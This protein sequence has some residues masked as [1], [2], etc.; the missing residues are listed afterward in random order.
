MSSHSNPLIAEL[1]QEILFA[2]PRVYQLADPTPLEKLETPYPFELYLKREDRSPIRAYK[3]RGAYNRMAQLSESELATGI[4]TASAGNHA[5]GV[6]LSAKKLG[7]SAVVYM[8]QSTPGV[9]QS[10]VKKLGGSHVKIVLA[11][12]SYDEAYA[13]ALEESKSTGK[14]Y[15][16]AYDEIAVMAG[17]GT[18]A[19]EVVMSNEGLLMSP[20]SKSEAGAWL[21]AL[22]AG[23]KFITRTSKSLVLRAKAKLPCKKQLKSANP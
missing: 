7:T 9:K 11:G 15:I 13:A 8:P 6:A 16:H 14:P 20:S 21:Q 4:V 2:R 23:S 19:D 3:W 17:Q 22:L 1:Q 5:Q 12:E 18:L 10:A